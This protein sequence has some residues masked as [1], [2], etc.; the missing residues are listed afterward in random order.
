[1]K[2]FAVLVALAFLAGSSHLLAAPTGPEYHQKIESVRTTAY[3]SG[4]ACNG[5]WSGR[6]AMGTRLKSG[7]IRSAAADWSHY[8]VG[9]RFRVVETGQEYVID[10]YGSAL[11]GTGTID[12]FKPSTREMNRWGVRRVTLEILEWGSPEKSLRILSNRTAVRHI[13]EMVD[14]LRQQDAV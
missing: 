12:L 13:R 7:T 14:R 1:M 4:A 6:N 11:I 9:T 10:D 3:T 2:F 8:P 5:E